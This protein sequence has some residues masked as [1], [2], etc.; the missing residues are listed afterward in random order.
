[1]GLRFLDRVLIGHEIFRSDLDD[2]PLKSIT[3]VIQRD[4]DFLIESVLS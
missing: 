2:D 4:A 1:M 3:Y